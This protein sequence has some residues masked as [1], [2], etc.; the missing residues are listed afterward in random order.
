[1]PLAVY[2]LKCALIECEIARINKEIARIYSTAPSDSATLRSLMQR[3]LELNAL[4]K[5]FAKYLG[6]RILSP[7]RP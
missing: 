7:H 1:M 6:E 5:E 2:N 3:N 4:K